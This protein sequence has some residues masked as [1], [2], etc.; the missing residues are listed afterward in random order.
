[1][2]ELRETVFEKDCIVCGTGLSLTEMDNKLEEYRRKLDRDQYPVKV[3]G[4]LKE[5]HEMIHWFAGK[6]VRNVAVRIR[7]YKM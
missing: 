5:V 2:K 6:H 1:M 7:N 4:V 3:T